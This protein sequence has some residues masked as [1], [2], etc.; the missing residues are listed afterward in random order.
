MSK[1]INREVSVVTV[2]TASLYG[3]V[4]VFQRGYAEFFGYPN[5]FI[6]V[7]LNMALSTGFIFLLL[8]S[9]VIFFANSLFF[10]SEFGFGK[11]VVVMVFIY[12]FVMAIKYGFKSAFYN[13]SDGAALARGGAIG[14]SFFLVLVFYSFKKMAL[15]SE[16]SDKYSKGTVFLMSIF[17]LAYS[18]GWLAAG[19]NNDIH[20]NSSGYYLISSYGDSHI[21]GKCL[22]NKS[23]FMKVNS[24]DS[25]YYKSELAGLNS[26]KRCFRKAS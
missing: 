15:A 21:I 9:S 13:S 6:F 20:Q 16:L 17:M 10:M 22:M 18:S 19:F 11:S 3:L 7:D 26:T 25:S 4:Y 23:E 1:I 24:L 12:I 14:F 5:E 8:V 2:L